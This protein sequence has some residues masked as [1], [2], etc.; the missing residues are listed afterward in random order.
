MT[1]EARHKYEFKRQLEELKSKQGQGTELISLYIP[2]DKRISDVVAYLR[3]EHGSAANIKSKSTRTNV[4]SALESIM[5]RLKYYKEPPENGMA[6]FCGAISIGGDRTS[7]E[8][9][10]IV[11]PQP[12]TSFSYRCGSN[13][14]TEKLE[15][16]LIDRKT[17]GLIVLDRREATIG[18]LK[19]KRVTPMRHLTSTVPGK[20]RKGGQSSHRFQQLRLIAIND[21]NNRIAEAANDIFLN[22]DRNDFQGILIGG[23]TPTKEEFVKG[24]YLHHE[25]QQKILGLFDV[26]YTDE[27]GL[28]E[29]MDAAAETLSA[30]EV[31]KEK[32]LMERFMKELVSDRGLAAYGE[33]SVRQNL[34]M[35]AVEVLLLSEDLRRSR[36]TLKCQ[37]CD[38]TSTTTVKH[39]A[40]EKATLEFGKCP[41]CQSALS[42]SEQVDVVDEL[43]VIAEQMN[44][45]V[46]FISTEFEEGEQL[47]NAFGGIAAILRYRTGV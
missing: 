31:V 30:L 44:T 14:E 35:G 7:M 9:I 20:Q 12:I 47:L 37:N 23:P 11:P 13:F 18:L 46:E 39:R 5:S 24:E 2:H 41:K 32:K 16:M 38:Y 33:D 19:G 40:G 36:I 6:I 27:S 15:E 1:E 28:E 3:D 10:T 4:Q 17:F 34:N 21:F 22:I 42:I 43:S 45:E 8:T 26:A 25:L 29:L